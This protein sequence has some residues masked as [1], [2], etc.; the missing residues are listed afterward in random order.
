LSDAP[1]GRGIARYSL[2]HG[3]KRNPFH[4]C[5]RDQNPIER[6]LMNRWQT[7]HRHYMLTGD[8]QLAVTVVEESAAQDP[9]VGFNILT[10]ELALNYVC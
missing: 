3:E 8:R 4:Y 2:V 1:H 9:S 10:S 5:L 6:I 7:L